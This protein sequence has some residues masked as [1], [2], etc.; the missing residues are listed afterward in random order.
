MKRRTALQLL[1]VIALPEQ[2]VHAAEATCGAS[3]GSRFENYKFAFF[4]PQEAELAARLMEIVIPTDENSPGARQ[5]KVAEFADLMLSTGSEDERKRWRLG[6]HLFELEAEKGT[7]DTAFREAANHEG[8]P[9]GE[10]DHFFIAL[11]HMTINGY[12]TSEIGIH[13]DLKYQ[14]NAHLTASPR[15][16]HPEHKA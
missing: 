14:G 16:D 6:L 2:L 7:L 10:L 9:S 8:A 11:K 4:T 12:Y 13:Q 3:G 15:C 5:A 1:P